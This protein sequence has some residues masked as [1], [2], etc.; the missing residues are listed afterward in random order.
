MNENHIEKIV[1]ESGIE[2][3][4]MHLRV[5]DTPITGRVHVI[6][7]LHTVIDTGGPSALARQD[8]FNGFQQ[9]RYDCGV[10]FTPAD[11]RHVLLTHGHKDHIGGLPLF[12]HPKCQTYLHFLD[13]KMVCEAQSFADLALRKLDRFFRISRT[14]EEDKPLL[15]ETFQSM[16]LRSSCY[17]IDHLIADRDKIGPFR[18]VHTPGHTRG[19]V[20]FLLDNVLFSGDQMM[21]QTITPP[22]WPY[23]FSR[24]QGYRNYIRSME[25]LKQTVDRLPIDFVLP[26]HEET[27][28]NPVERLQTIKKAEI[29]RFKRILDY[30]QIGNPTDSLEI[31]A[32]SAPEGIIR[33]ASEFTKRFYII[34]TDHFSVINL[35]DAASRLEFIAQQRHHPM[36][37]MLGEILH[38]GKVA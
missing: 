10:R 29:R 28:T 3:Y 24:H 33:S 11:V 34:P 4:A 20:C 27:I 2:I 1:T 17:P 21:S 12:S 31:R 25:R 35:F 7:E 36:S 13:R 32:L 18:V 22:L 15:I 8:L 14:P 6:P 30:L 26:S 5:L 23:C 9:L 19:Q 37:I 16:W 38:P